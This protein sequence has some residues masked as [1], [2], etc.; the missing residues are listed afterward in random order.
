MKQEKIVLARE[1][2][3]QGEIQLQQWIETDSP[4]QPVYEI[5][6]NGVFLMASYN[7]RSEKA[8]AT[9]AIEPLAGDRRAMRALIGGL[10]MGY[11]LQAALD[12]GIQVVDVVEIEE[13]II[14]W[15][16]RFFG[17]LNGYALS[18]PRVRLINMDLGDYLFQTEETYDAIILDVDNGP[19]WLAL[20]SN[21]RLYE[22]PTLARMKDLLT[23]GG[24]LTVW[25][26][27]KCPDF[28]KRL[29]KIFGRVEEI[30]IQETDRRGRPTD[31]FIY[32]ARSLDEG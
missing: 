28:Q 15:A 3:P 12:Y 6:F 20:E 27:E 24:V 10:G 16:Q 1:T 26:A 18:D 4:N 9:L 17:E 8:V 7:E 32:R 2:T 5:I 21:Q 30:T 11:T 25:A 13:H 29:E 19:T 23:K 14:V 31:C 22:R